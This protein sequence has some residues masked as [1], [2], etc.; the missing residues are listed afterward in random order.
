MPL[1]MEFGADKGFC[2]VRGGRIWYRLYQPTAIANS[3]PLVMLHGG[4]GAPHDYLEP[5]AEAIAEKGRPML[6]YDQLS[7]GRSDYPRDVSLWH[8]GCSVEDM[9]PV[10]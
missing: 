10:T 3:V 4:P 1:S 9:V 6:V 7:C 5:V 8:A 2:A